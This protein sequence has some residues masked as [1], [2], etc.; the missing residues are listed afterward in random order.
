[1]STAKT[2]SLNSSSHKINF[3]VESEP[4]PP[5]VTIKCTTTATSFMTVDGDSVNINSNVDSSSRTGIINITAVTTA[6][7]AYNGIASATS[8]YTVTQGE[9]IP[10]VTYFTAYLERPDDISVRN[11]YYITMNFHC[12]FGAWVVVIIDG[13]VTKLDGR[14]Q[15]QM[16][17]G[18][19]G[20]NSIWGGQVPFRSGS[21]STPYEIKYDSKYA[22]K[23]IQIGYC[24]RINELDSDNYAINL[25]TSS[26]NTKISY[27]RPILIEE[28]MLFVKDITMPS[29]GGTIYDVERDKAVF[30]FTS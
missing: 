25:K 10:P 18:F 20:N 7:S 13:V 14:G 19:G 12:N 11:D 27:Y 21:V 9:Y 5:Q 6:D 24:I 22:G 4:T 16:A 3:T 26:L 30:E 23:T 15:T 1:M 29:N 17:P 28:D 2:I 8:S